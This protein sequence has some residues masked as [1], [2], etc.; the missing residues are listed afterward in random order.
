MRV[1]VSSLKLAVM[2]TILSFC[3][4]RLA[5]F[6]KVIVHFIQGLTPPTLDHPDKIGS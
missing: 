6:L 1:I 5:E 3:N 4:G 2:L